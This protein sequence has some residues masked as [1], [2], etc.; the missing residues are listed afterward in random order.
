M[1]FFFPGGSSSFPKSAQ[2]IWDK[3]VAAN[4][5]G[6]Y[7][8]MWGTCM[9]FQWLLIAA[10]GDSSVLDPKSGQMDSYNYSIPLEFT[11]ATT[12]SKLFGNAPADVMD[13]LSTKNVTMNNHHYGIWTENFK[14]NTVLSSMF[15][16]LSTNDDRN[17]DN[18][19]SSIEGFKYPIFGSQWHPEK[20]NFEWGRETTGVPKEAIDHSPE[21]VL[22]TQYVSDVFVQHARMNTHSFPTPADEDAALIYNYSPSKTTGSFV[23][24]YFFHVDDEVKGRL[25]KDVLLGGEKP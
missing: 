24:S 1:V 21:A 4:D 3:V 2:Y 7:F 9:G 22:I 10:T 12:G 6:D 20:N 19:V 18:F 15:N 11:S 23:Q 13:I 25:H 8:P 17:G 16:L 5:A 14:K